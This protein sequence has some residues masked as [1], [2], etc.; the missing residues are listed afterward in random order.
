M[1]DSIIR[2]I[3]VRIPISSTDARALS[4][5]AS[6]VGRCTSARVEAAEALR[7]DALLLDD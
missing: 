5:N 4:E 3:V 7:P 2:L 1:R 6:N